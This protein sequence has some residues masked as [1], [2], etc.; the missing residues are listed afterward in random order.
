MNRWRWQA[1]RLMERGGPAGV[2]AAVVGVLT[3]AAWLAPGLSMSAEARAL[4]SDNDALQR[5]AASTPRAASAPPNSQQQLVAFE[6][7]FPGPRQVGASYTRLWNLARHHGI[8]LRQADFKLTDGA[9]D[10]LQRYTILVPVTADYASLRAFVID[11]LRDQPGLA[12]EEMNVRRGDSKS[13][14][15]EARLNFV[16]FVRRGD[17]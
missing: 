13:L 12:L 8:A 16:L 7:G 3:L 5:R 2:V 4:A 14:Q 1:Q 6:N 15:V 9:Q 17:A 11:A 10:D